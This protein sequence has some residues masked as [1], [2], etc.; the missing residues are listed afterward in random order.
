VPRMAMTTSNSIRVKPLFPYLKNFILNL[1]ILF[2]VWTAST[3]S[4]F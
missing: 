3:F 4:P 2:M 1:L